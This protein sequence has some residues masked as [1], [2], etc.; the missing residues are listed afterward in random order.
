LEEEKKMSVERN[1]GENG[2]KSLDL[3]RKLTDY[4]GN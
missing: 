1:V 2:N 4:L 3:M